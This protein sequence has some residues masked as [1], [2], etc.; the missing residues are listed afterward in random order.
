[1]CG[2][3]K[4]LR[5]HVRRRGWGFDMVIRGW[6]NWFKISARLGSDVMLYHTMVHDMLT[7][8]HDRAES[9]RSRRGLSSLGLLLPSQRAIV[10]IRIEHIN[11]DVYSFCSPKICAPKPRHEKVG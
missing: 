4:E 10:D 11:H 7:M 5:W 3:G 8:N 2:T 1:M 6:D 9:E